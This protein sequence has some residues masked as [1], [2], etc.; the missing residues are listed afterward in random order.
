MADQAPSAIRSIVAAYCPTTPGRAWWNLHPEA[1]L[2]PPAWERLVAE[3]EAYGDERAR[4][5][6]ALGRE[7][8][9]LSV[10]AVRREAR[11]AAIHAFTAAILHGD[12]D[13][14]HRAWLKDAAMAFLNDQP[15]QGLADTPPSPPEPEWIEWHGG[16]CPVPPDTMVECRRG[17]GI[18]I[19]DLAFKWRWHYRRIDTDIIAYRVVL[20]VNHPLRES[21]RGED[22]KLP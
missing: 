5:A 22:G 1:L 19:K 8:T 21:V 15:I 11:A 9:R 2:M 16:D 7:A 13:P 14:L 17:D 20:G 3:L 4:E 12:A 18:I 6:A 10:N